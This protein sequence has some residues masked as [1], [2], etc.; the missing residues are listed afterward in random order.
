MNIK[1]AEK[2]MFFHTLCLWGFIGSIVLAVAAATELKGALS[3]ILVPTGILLML[4]AWLAFNV[5][6]VMLGVFLEKTWVGWLA[7]SVLL[8][9]VGM[10]I[11]YFSARSAA[12]DAI[13]A[14]NYPEYAQTK[15][16]RPTTR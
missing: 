3:D 15:R 10:L 2:F 1:K 6:V 5:G 11:A 7:A 4:A 8:G 13:T 14:T 16:K 9:P 12:Q